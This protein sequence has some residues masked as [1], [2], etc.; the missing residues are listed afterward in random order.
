MIQHICEKSSI[1]GEKFI[2]Q[3]GRTEA[4]LMMI[5]FLAEKIIAN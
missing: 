1:E 3:K 2:H 5:A 4:F